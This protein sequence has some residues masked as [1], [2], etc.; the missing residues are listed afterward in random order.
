VSSETIRHL[1][2]ASGITGES[3][4]WRQGM[5]DWTPLRDVPEL[6]GDDA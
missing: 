5:V 2:A 6:A 4:V 1:R 3:L